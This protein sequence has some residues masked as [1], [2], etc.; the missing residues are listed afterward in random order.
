MN[1]VIVGIIAVVCLCSGLFIGILVN[2]AVPVS[3]LNTESRDII[4]L[5]TAMMGTLTALVLALLIS[6]AKDSFQTRDNE[7]RQTAANLMLMDRAMAHYGTETENARSLLR[8]I[9]VSRLQ[10]MQVQTGDGSRQEREDTE[11]IEDVQDILAALAP[12][13][14]AQRWLQSR[15]LQASADVSQMKWLI[16]DQTGG[17]IQWPFIVIL[18]FWLSMIFMVFGLLAPRNAT[19]V[20]VLMLSAVSVSVAIFLIVDMDQPYHGLI[21]NSSQPLERAIDL[22]D[23]CSGRS[24]PC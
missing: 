13:N 1:P 10:Q 5:A 16:F 2:T 15:A 17:I 20:S 23:A 19:V 18:M 22:L 11:K 9:F 6:S 8:K 7:V 4:K 3:H 21:M 14:G 12:Q 24:H